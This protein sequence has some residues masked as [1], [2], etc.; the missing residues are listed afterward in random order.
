MK[1]GQ[2]F[3]FIMMLLMGENSVQETN[4]YEKKCTIILRH[5]QGSVVCYLGYLN[6]VIS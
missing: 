6:S 5:T 4:K 1:A 3:I 2:D